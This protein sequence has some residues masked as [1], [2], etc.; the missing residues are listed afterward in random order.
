MNKLL[1]ILIKW[2]IRR[3][4]FHTDVQKMYNSVRLDEEHW[5]YQLYFWG[6]NLSPNIQPRTKVIKTLIYGLK[7]SENQAEGALR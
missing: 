1:Q 4:A 7:P 5:N 2:L 3:C 6:K